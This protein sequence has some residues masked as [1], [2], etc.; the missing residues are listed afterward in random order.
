MDYLA[1]TAKGE[2]FAEAFE[3]AFGM[4]AEDF[5]KDLRD[6]YRKGRVRFIKLKGGDFFAPVKP[7]AR[8]LSAAESRLMAYQQRV[9]MAGFRAAGSD[10]DEGGSDEGEAPATAADSADSPA[11]QALAELRS[12]VALYAAGDDREASFYA[13][14]LLAQAEMQAGNAAAAE[15][16]ATALVAENG[17]DFASALVLAQSLTRQLLTGSARDGAEEGLVVKARRAAVAANRLNPY[18]PRALY[19]FHRVQNF[20]GLAN[21]MSLAGLER[22]HEIQPQSME[23]KSA[24]IETYV[25]EDRLDEAIGLLRQIA[26]APHAGA[27][28]LQARSYMEQLEARRSAISAPLVSPAATAAADAEADGAP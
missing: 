13:R 8:A 16:L 24:L 28:G 11:A 15:T 23:L 1:R 6:Y 22:A 5:D 4:T 3:A 10:E 27:R 21:E 17:K 7:T 14:R 18:D 26:Y 19:L 9:W 12:E 20:A 25:R 2:A